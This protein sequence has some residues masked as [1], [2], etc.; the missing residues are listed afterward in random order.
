LYYLYGVDGWNIDIWQYSILV[1]YENDDKI[2][3]N[4]DSM[5]KLGYV[6]VNK[7]TDKFVEEIINE[8]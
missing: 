4:C 6:I 5:A 1:E 7:F 8:V 2:T 3:V